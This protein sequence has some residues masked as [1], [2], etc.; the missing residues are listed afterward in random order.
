MYMDDID[1]ALI[2]L[3]REDASQPSKTL[4]AAVGLSP[5]SVRERIEK[6]QEVG[7]IRR[8]T[9]ELSPK[10]D[11][12]AAILSIKLRKTPDPVVVQALTRRGDVRRLYSISGG[13]DLFAELV[14]PDIDAINAAR[15]EIASLPGVADLETAFVLKREKV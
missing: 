1:R 2:A 11:A 3:L 14:G 5:S 10:A 7:I 8:F 15:D 9:I 6:L 4:A 12:V 13:V